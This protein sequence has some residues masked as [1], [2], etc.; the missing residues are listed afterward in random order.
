MI[1]NVADKNERGTANSTLL[2]SWDL[3]LGIGILLGGLLT[4]HISYRFAFWTIAAIHAA[5]A[6]FFMVTRADYLKRTNPR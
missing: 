4:E 1:I 2:T 6:L 3:G 5:G